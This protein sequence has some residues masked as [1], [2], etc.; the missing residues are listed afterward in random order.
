M[1][2][3]RQ[4]QLRIEQ[5]AVS[6]HGMQ[7]RLWDETMSGSDAVSA[8]VWPLKGRHLGLILGRIQAV[9]GLIALLKL[10]WGLSGRSGLNP[11]H[12]TVSRGSKIPGTGSRLGTNIIA[13]G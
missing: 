3:P 4:G 2:S 1:L 10:S 6:G 8:S 7:H 5:Y 9:D 11:G 12:G 13:E